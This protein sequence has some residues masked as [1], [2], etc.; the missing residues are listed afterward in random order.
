MSN[1]SNITPYVPKSLSG[2]TTTSDG[3]STADL[4]QNFLRLLTAQLRNQDP[5]NPID[6][7]NMTTQLAALNQVDGINRLN[8]SM[9][10][11]L[12]QMVSASFVGLSSSVG[13]SALTQSDQVYFTGEPVSLAVGVNQLAPNATLTIYNSANEPIRQMNLGAIGA[14]ITDILW[15]GDNDS[16]EQVAAG[17]MYRIELSVP[18]APAELQSKTFVGSPV[19]A[20]GRD[21]EE[22]MATLADGRS[23]SIDQIIK[24][25]AI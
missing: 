14:G 8:K 16:G 19:V 13:K 5:L 25:L 10:S 21:G 23:V 11:M 2:A 18:D 7:A 1:L 20:I 4:S 6:N 15:A 9:E 3:T 12:N 22:I 17:E 24:W